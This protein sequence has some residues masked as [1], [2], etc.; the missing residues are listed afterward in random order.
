[1]T[2]NYDIS[3]YIKEIKIKVL[4]IPDVHGSHEWEKENSY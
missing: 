4:V 3:I 1:M 2:R